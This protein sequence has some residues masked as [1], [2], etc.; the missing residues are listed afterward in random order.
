MNVIS[1]IKKYGFN[2]AFALATLYWV[3]IGIKVYREENPV[4]PSVLEAFKKGGYEI[5]CH[6]EDGKDRVSGWFYTHED[7]YFT[8]RNNSSEKYSIDN[9][10][11]V[12]KL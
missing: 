4:M 9:C 2:I 7:G 1:F 10:V 8:K 12:E 11:V 5:E 6:N 3:A